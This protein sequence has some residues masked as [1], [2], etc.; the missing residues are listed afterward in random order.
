[1]V[2]EKGLLEYGL[3]HGVDSGLG[4]QAYNSLSCTWAGNT[5][6]A[7][8]VAPFLGSPVRK[9]YCLKDRH[10]PLLRSQSEAEKDKVRQEEQR[11]QASRG[12]GFCERK[13]ISCLHS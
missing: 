11:E 3:G 5:L 4:Q 1:M 13:Y 9:D 12:G 2:Y 8:N 10:L 7:R 6:S